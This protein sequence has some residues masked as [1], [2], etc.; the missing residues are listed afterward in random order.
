EF[1]L[2][3]R[4]FGLEPLGLLRWGATAPDKLRAA[5]RGGLEGV[6]S[7]ENTTIDL[8]RGE[9]IIRDKRYGMMMH[10]FLFESSISHQELLDKMC[11]RMDYLRRKLINDIESGEKIFVYQKADLRDEEATG[12]HQAIRALGENVLLCVRLADEAHSAGT[13]ESTW[14]GLLIG[15][16]D[17]PGNRP[18]CN[19]DISYG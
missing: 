6:G 19:W 11:R 16:L 15:Y 1:G 9:Y 17:R 4:H 7:L 3:Q 2:V 5:L 12:L 10:T 13:V 8:V 18:P 14:E